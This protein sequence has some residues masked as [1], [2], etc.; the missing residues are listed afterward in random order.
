MT[1]WTFIALVLTAGVFWLVGVLT[2]AWAMSV[3]DRHRHEQHLA[4]HR[5]PHTGDLTND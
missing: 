3:E 1:G 2:V 4:R 5:T